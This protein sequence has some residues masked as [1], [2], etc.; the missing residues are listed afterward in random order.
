MTRQ[1]QEYTNE[2][3]VPGILPTG[4]LPTVVLDKIETYVTLFQFISS[5]IPREYFG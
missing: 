3:D 2:G 5:K 4:I 1:I